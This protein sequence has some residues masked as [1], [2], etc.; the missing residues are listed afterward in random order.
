MK[1]TIA[2]LSAMGIAGALYF[3][4]GTDEDQRKPKD[5]YLLNRV[6]TKKIPG[7]SNARSTTFRLAL[8]DKAKQRLGFVSDMSSWRVYAELLRYRVERNRLTVEFPQNNLKHTFSFRT[9]RCKDAPKPFDLC[10]EL[11]GKEGRTVLYSREDAILAQ[12]KGDLTAL[13]PALWSNTDPWNDPAVQTVLQDP[14]EDCQE[15]LPSA[16]ERL[17][18]TEE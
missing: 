12:T 2:L 1:G 13:S 3:Q 6:W 10:L 16:L 7:S 11:K 4:C 18:E 17:F 14:C 9:W 8:L 5:K 15:K